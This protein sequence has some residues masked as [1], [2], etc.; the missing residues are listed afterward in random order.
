LNKPTKAE[1]FNEFKCVHDIGGS[2]IVYVLI[3]VLESLYYISGDISPE[4]K[5]VVARKVA[6]S[7]RIAS[8]VSDEG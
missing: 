5:N 3:S 6:S 4:F 8:K 1:G 2:H 7:I